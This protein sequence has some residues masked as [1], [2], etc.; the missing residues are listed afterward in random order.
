MVGKL[1]EHFLYFLQQGQPQDELGQ[2]G[3]LWML[4]AATL[5]RE[6]EKFSLSGEGHKL[7]LITRLGRVIRDRE[8]KML[9]MGP[10]HEKQISYDVTPI[11]KVVLFVH[12]PIKFNFNF[13]LMQ[14]ICPGILRLWRER[15]L[16][17]LLRATV[18]TLTRARM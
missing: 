15:K 9:T 18:L 16:R 17:A 3:Q 8:R 5:R 12:D 14:R 11:H 1:R 10:E 13:R 2:V 4:S 6:G 7:E